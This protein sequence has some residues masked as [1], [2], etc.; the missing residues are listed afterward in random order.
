MRRPQK[1][2]SFTPTK[3]E[4]PCAYEILIAL[5]KSSEKTYRSLMFSISALFIARSDR[6]FEWFRC[7]TE[8]ALKFSAIVNYFKTDWFSWM[9]IVSVLTQ[10]LLFTRGPKIIIASLLQKHHFRTHLLP[11]VFKVKGIVV[12]LNRFSNLNRLCSL[13]KDPSFKSRA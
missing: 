13:A 6:Q 10:P 3:G 11:E 5:S 1:M 8:S 7:C 12:L 4:A 2:K 9:G